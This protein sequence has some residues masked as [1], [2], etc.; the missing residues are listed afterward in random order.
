VTIPPA[1]PVPQGSGQT[2]LWH[3]QARRGDTSDEMVISVGYPGVLA[4]LNLVTAAK[5][6]GAIDIVIPY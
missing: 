2:L 6:I 4:L 5:Q 1:A 3:F